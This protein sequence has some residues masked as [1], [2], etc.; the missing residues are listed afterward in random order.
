MPEWIR[1]SACKA[2]S[3]MCAEVS[4]D[5]KDG[6]LIRSSREPHRSIRLD[7]DEWAVFKAGI[8]VGDFDELPD[9]DFA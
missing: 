6:V 9:V 3:P 2:D 7:A 5:L 8:V 4:R 1:S